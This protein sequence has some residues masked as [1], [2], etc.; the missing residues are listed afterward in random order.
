MQYGAGVSHLLD[1]LEL[2]VGMGLMLSI[3]ACTVL[4]KKR[5]SDLMHSGLIVIVLI[6]LIGVIVVLFYYRLV[7]A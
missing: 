5:K 6:V 4:V 2:G 3:F 1:I 7:T